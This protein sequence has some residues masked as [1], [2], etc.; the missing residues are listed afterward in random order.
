MIAVV[1]LAIFCTLFY[2]F[3]K[4]RYTYWKRLGVPGPEPSFIVGNVGPFLNMSSHMSMLCEKWY[5]YVILFILGRT[6]L[7][8]NH[9][10][11]RDFP[12]DAY[13]GYY[14]MLSPAI[15]V[16][17][18]DLVKDILMKD[19]FS[20]HKNEQ[21]F[22]KSFDPL[23]AHNPFVATNE[24]WKRSRSFL[25]PLS[26]AFRVKTLFPLIVDSCNRMTSHL[27]TLSPTDHIETK[28]LSS[29]FATQNV[30]MC[31]FSIDSECFGNGHSEFNELGKKIFDPTDFGGIILM[32]MT[33]CPFLVDVIPLP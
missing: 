19:H 14:K 1:F 17:D 25:T 10:V 29:K 24:H 15:N 7:N 28:D 6:I 32:F 23:M 20:W 16:R 12:N 9:F 18:P 4:I 11:C 2:V 26:T 27:K 22:S 13:C 33:V 21:H 31:S 30:I 8:I 3:V 5:K